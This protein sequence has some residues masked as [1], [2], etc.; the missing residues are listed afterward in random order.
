MEH[1]KLRR[2]MPSDLDAVRRLHVEGLKQTGS[3]LAN[4]AYDADLNRIEEEY[5]DRNGEFLVAVYDDNN[6]VEFHLG[7]HPLNKGIKRL[8]SWLQ[9]IRGED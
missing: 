3:Y 6:I 1:V 2:Y 4:P 5:I 7:Y 8:M 9:T